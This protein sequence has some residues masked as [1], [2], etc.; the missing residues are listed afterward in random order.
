[1]RLLSLLGLSLVAAQNIYRSCDGLFKLHKTTVHVNKTV[2]VTLD[3]TVPTKITNGTME[4]QVYYNY[5]PF[6]KYTEDLC[7]R[8]A[9][10]IKPGHHVET[11][12]YTLS[13]TGNIQAQVK[14]FDKNNTQLLCIIVVL[15]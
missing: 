11:Y 4:T 2:S 3:Y 13:V 10:P 14:W 7:N 9:C 15:R 6:P 8:V 1:M 12:N 5:I